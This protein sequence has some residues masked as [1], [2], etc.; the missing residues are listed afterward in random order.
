MA[1]HKKGLPQKE[2]DIITADVLCQVLRIVYHK[3]EYQKE[4]INLMGEILKITERL[5]DGNDKS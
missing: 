1:W 2:K 4:T 5:E 3:P